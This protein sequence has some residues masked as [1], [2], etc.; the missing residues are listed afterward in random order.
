MLV[1]IVKLVNTGK[2]NGEGRETR[3]VG[4]ELTS[5]SFTIEYRTIYKG[6]SSLVKALTVAVH[7]LKV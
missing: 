4:S 6:N 5:N 2:E 3:E 7:W 1:S